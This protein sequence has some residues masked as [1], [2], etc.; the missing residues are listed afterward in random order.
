MMTHPTNR[1]GVPCT[2]VGSL[3]RSVILACLL[4][5]LVNQHLIVNKWLAISLADVCSLFTL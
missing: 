2:V 5:Y 3:G 1:I 4:E